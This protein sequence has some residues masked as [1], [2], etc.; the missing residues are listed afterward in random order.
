M[1]QPQQQQPQTPRDVK[2]T[3]PEILGEI[4]LLAIVFG[5]AVYYI[6]ELP[7]LPWAGRHLPIITIAVTT[8][9]WLWRVRTLFLRKKWLQSGAIMDLGF[10]FGDDPVGERRRAV[11]YVSAV[12]T[13]FI[14]LWVF[15]FHIFLPLWVMG[16]M[17]LFHKGK[18]NPLI[19]VIIGVAFEGLLLG[20]H[21]Y[22]I[23]VPWPQPLFW[24]MI[25]VDYLFNDWPISET[26]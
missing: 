25:G 1:E 4:V 14:G 20:V 17:F 23:D 19:I 16:Y 15:G 11:Q 5:F 7:R 3:S 6:A 10:R 26:Y 18:L 2:W 22:I 13:L 24:R 8:P 12:A 9:F 21:D